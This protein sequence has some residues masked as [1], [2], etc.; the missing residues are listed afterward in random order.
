MKKSLTP[1]LPFSI[2]C[3]VYTHIT[4]KVPRVAKDTRNWN[5]LQIMMATDV[6]FHDAT[7]ACV[8]LITGAPRTVSPAACAGVQTEGSVCIKLRLSAPRLDEGNNVRW[9]SS[10]VKSYQGWPT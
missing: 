10:A 6:S 2:L 9:K 4:G 1:S 7:H 5:R 8:C 3:Q